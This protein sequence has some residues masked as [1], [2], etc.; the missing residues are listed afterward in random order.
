[1][2]Q[3]LQW[4]VLNPTFENLYNRLADEISILSGVKSIT[5]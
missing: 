4:K 1:L 3:K 2:I 5:F